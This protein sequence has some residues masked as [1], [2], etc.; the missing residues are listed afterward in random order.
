MLGMRGNIFREGVPS[1]SDLR[2]GEEMKDEIFV[3]ITDEPM[4]R[5]EAPWEACDLNVS[6]AR[7]LAGKLLEQVDMLEKRLS[8]PYSGVVN[9][10]ESVAAE[11]LEHEIAR[12][13][14]FH[15]R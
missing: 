6:D 3:R 2:D 11:A 4:I 9:D 13:V 10:D 5:I 14:L 7:L 12:R 15:G 8:T 1:M